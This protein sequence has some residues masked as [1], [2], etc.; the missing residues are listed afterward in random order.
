MDYIRTLPRAYII[1]IHLSTVVLLI[2]VL[3]V[4]IVSMCAPCTHIKYDYA[5]W[6]GK[7]VLCVTWTTLAYILTGYVCKY[8]LVHCSYIC[9]HLSECCM[10]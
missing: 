1:H 8:V 3:Y 9:Q 5:V 7:A 6:V 4:Y 10:Q 2:L